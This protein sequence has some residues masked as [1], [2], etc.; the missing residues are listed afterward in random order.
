MSLRVWPRSHQRLP[1]IQ[2][3]KWLTVLGE[4]SDTLVELV[5]S[6]LVLEH[7]PSE[8]G[9]VVKERDLLHLLAV[10]LGGVELLGDG[11]GRVLEL[12]EELGG[13]GEVVA[14]GQ[15][16]DFTNVSERSTHDDGLVAVL[17][18]VAACQ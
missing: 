4:T 15:L 16:G 5:E 18:V 2:K 14:S 3:S 9:L 10:D 12:F 1:L 7:G 13:N 17:L 11:L 6:H 8:L